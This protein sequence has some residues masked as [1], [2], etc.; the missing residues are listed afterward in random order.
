MATVNVDPRQAINDVVSWVHWLA[1]LIVDLGVSILFA[2]VVLKLFGF[3]NLHLPT[4][5][6]TQ[7]A[8]LMFAYAAYKFKGRL[9]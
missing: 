4:P 9:V 7:L 8:W 1:N 2:A 5:S 6:E 3:G